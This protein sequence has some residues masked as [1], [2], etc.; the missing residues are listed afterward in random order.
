MTF[1][2]EIVLMLVVGGGSA[3]LVRFVMPVALQVLTFLLVRI[4]SVLA[5]IAL[6]PDVIVAAPARRRS[7]APPR[8]AYEYGDAIGAAAQM[9]R[10]A[11]RQ[12]CRGLIRVARNLPL[13]LVAVVAA[14]I[15]LLSVLS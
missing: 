1:L 5:A 6:L 2:R 7:N 4:L 12:V 11:L 15:Q 10:L 8:W 3:L 13:G 14:G 9:I